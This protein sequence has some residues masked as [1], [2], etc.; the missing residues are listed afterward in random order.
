MNFLSH[1][2]IADGVDCDELPYGT[3]RF[4]AQQAAG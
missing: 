1:L 3:S 4:L 2:W